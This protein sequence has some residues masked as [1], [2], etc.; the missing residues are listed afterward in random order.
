MLVI[1]ENE[2]GIDQKLGIGASE[3]G[4]GPAVFSVGGK[5]IKCAESFCVA[6]IDGVR[7]G[8]SDVITR[9][10][11]VGIVEVIV[12]DPGIINWGLVSN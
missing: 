2:G 4:Q 10:V 3:L 11:A 9:D 12:D 5:G 7:V 8:L 6:D 1:E